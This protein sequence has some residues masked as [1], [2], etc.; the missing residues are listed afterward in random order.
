MARVNVPLTSQVPNGSVVT[1]PSGGTP[2]DATDGHV[3]AVSGLWPA[4]TLEEI[5]LRVTNGATDA[6]ITV[7]AGSNPPALEAGLGDL[8]ATVAANTTRDFGPFSSGRFL[9]DA[10]DDDAAGLWVDIDDATNVTVMAVHT[11]RSA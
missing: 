6:E 7:L 10:T 1:T 2:G 3:V 8:V 11:P 4:P 9:Q 5:T